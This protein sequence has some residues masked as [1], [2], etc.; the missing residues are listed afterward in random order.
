MKY[1]VWLIN[2]LNIVNRD[3]E[4]CKFIKASVI[5]DRIISSEKRFFMKAEDNVAD[6][7]VAV[8]NAIHEKFVSLSLC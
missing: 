5:N 2:D 4:L 8:I 3:N 7:D 1:D 6:R